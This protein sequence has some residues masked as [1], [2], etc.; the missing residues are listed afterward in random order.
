MAAYGNET[1]YGL[2]LAEY[3]EKM[4]STRVQPATGALF[5]TCRQHYDADN[6]QHVAADGLILPHQI[7]DHKFEEF[8]KAEISAVALKYIIVGFNC[9]L[10]KLLVPIMEQVGYK[11]EDKLLLYITE[12]VFMCNIFNT[13]LLPMLCSANLED[14]LPNWMF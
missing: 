10:R 6:A 9:I 12:I 7:C 2:A 11:T 14:E 5:C 3:Q 1:I 4:A 8:K 13:A